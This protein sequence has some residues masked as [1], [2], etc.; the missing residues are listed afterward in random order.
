M[1]TV[2]L[3][4]GIAMPKLGFGVFQI[5][6]GDTK[7]CVLD[8]FEVGYR[9]I[10]T[11]QSYMNEAGVGAA[12]RESGL[13][14]EDLFITTKVWIDN[15][16]AGKTRDSLMRSLERLGMEYIDLV[17]LHQ[18]I[19][20]YY[21]AWR[22]LEALYHEG[23]LRSIGVS[24]FSPKELADIAAFNEVKPAVNQIEVNPL[25]QQIPAHENMLKR[26]IQ[27]A[28]WAPFGEGKA[29]VLQNPVLGG[30]AKTH[31]KTIAQVILRWL[32]QRDVVTLVKSTHKERMQ[33][34][35]DI[36]DFTLSEEE[37]AL[38]SSLDT[39]ESIF[40]SMSSPETVDMFVELIE[41]RKGLC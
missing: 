30:V 16:G 15:F 37:M 31:G 33:Q 25:H 35:F 7:R 12:V 8:A 5:P 28:A 32:M 18:P 21:S 13:P 36:F 1:E 39:G 20:D 10:D 6:A 41:K 24:N 38:I 29:G 22:D 40:F 23:V 3:N 14:R 19:G 17:L 11:A 34:N 2:I 4:N 9:H 26:G 27:M